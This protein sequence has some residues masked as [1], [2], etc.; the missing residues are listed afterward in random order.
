[1]KTLREFYK[2][3]VSIFI[4]ILIVTLH[5]YSQG[6]SGKG[7]LKGIVCDADTGEPIENVAVKLYSLRAAAYYQPEPLTQADGTWHVYF[8]QGGDWDID[9]TRDGYEPKKI[10]FR[11]DTRSGKKIPLIRIELKKATTPVLEEGIAAEVKVAV[12]SLDQGRFDEALTKFQAILGKSKE[13]NTIQLVHKLM[14]NCYAGLG[15]YQE[16]II[17]YRK[18]LE[19]SPDDTSLLISIGSS[20]T[21]LGDSAGALEIFKKIPL[22][23]IS[24]VDTLYN[25]GAIY[26]NNNHFTEA[27]KYL[28]KSVKTNEAFADG[29]YLLGMTY[30]ALNETKKAVTV[31]RKF[32]ETA[33]GSPEAQT[34][35]S[36]VEAFGNP[37]K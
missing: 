15:N 13:E 34:A 36:I 35:R 7:K 24:D 3:S 8:I 28:E 30:T 23:S 21:N 27:L 4:I 10:S 22:E 25:I 32:I 19:K 26:Y 9:F 14:G 11:V 18:A 20:L 33:P 6:I 12:A 29:Y 31:L 37:E 2:I 16:A 1:M 17:Y 5:A